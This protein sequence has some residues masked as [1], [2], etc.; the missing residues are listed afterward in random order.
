MEHRSSSESRFFD[1]FSDATSDSRSLAETVGF[2]L[3][4]R[5]LGK[6]VEHALQA[7]LAGGVVF[8]DGTDPLSIFRRALAASVRDIESHPRG[9]L[10]REFLWKGPYHNVGKIPLAS[11]NELSLFTT[12]TGTA[13]HSG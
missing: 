7:A 13:T 9:R 8:P 10:L 2:E 12:A 4:G 3:V 1:A 5:D 11:N 6:D